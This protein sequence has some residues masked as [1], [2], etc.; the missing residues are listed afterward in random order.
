MY[1]FGKKTVHQRLIGG[2]RM[3]LD[4]NDTLA[5]QI[6]CEETF[7]PEVRREIVRIASRGVNVIDIGANIG[8]YTVLTSELIGPEKRVFSFEPQARMVAK[9]RRNIELNAQGN[10]EVFPFALADAPGTVTFHVPS[11]GNEGFGSMRANGR[12]DVMKT[13][14]VATQR[15]DDVLSE[16]GTPKIGLVK[17]DAEGAELLIL[18]GATQLL[19]SP[20]KPSLIFEANES[21]CKPFGYCVFDLLQ[22]VHG[23]G[24]RLRQLDNEDWLAE[25]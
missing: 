14:E 17:M 3:I 6:R 1:A 7:E 10:V 21:N 2:G 22:F 12:F 25:S 5:Q 15:L 23:F 9:L 13:V 20:D 11:E 8:Y 4:T 19:S 18:R 24:Y 16:L